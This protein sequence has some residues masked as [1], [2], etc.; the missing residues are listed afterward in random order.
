MQKML[1][2]ST[3]LASSLLADT[4]LGEKISLSSAQ[5]TIVQTPLQTRVNPNQQARQT[6]PMSITNNQ[7]SQL[8]TR[9][10]PNNVK[11]S[12]RKDHHRY[13][14]RYSSFDY[15]RYG[16]YND[17]GYYYGYFDKR[18]YFYN[19]IFFT[20]NH[21]YTYH[22]RFYRR[23]PFAHEHHHRRR[24]LHHT[25]NDWN[26]VHHYRQPNHIVYG[27]YYDQTYHPHQHYSNHYNSHYNYPPARMNVTRMNGYNHNT[28][29]NNYNHS[30]NRDNNARM[31]VTRMNG[32]HNRSYN[33]RQNYNRHNNYR[34]SS[35]YQNRSNQIR[36]S[37]ARMTT[38]NSQGRHM[39]MSR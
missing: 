27:H 17:E 28:N 37:T 3:L 25:F 15:D 18:G 6:Q 26:R 23:G 10:S 19:N 14:K 22:D 31:S 16:Y 11:R 2:V 12:F 36:R 4:H 33:S 39:G 21:I 34:S 30:Y 35:S 13:D 24:Y 1:L 32:T 5:E 9:V 20:Y 8:N 7:N 38:R 29:H